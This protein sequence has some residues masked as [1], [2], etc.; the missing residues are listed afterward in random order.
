MRLK[1][2]P[3]AYEPS[4]YEDKIY[5]EWEESG[6]FNPDNLPTKPEAETYTI[7]MPPPNVTGVLH[8]GHAA[9]LALEDILI[10]YHRMQGKRTL[11]L[12]G[13]DHAAIATQTKVEK[14][15]K[16]EGLSRHSLGRE[17]FLARVREFAAQSHDTI[18]GQVKKM[19]SSC[20]WS[21]E[22]YTLDEIRTRAVRSVFKMMYD[23]GLIYRG[24]RIVNWCPRC[25]STLA[26][27]EV[28]YKTQT[29]KLYTFKYSKDFPF[30]IAT[31]RPETKLGDT[32][33]AVNPK[34]ER[35]KKYIGKTFIVDFVGVQL[36]LKIIADRSVD[37]EFGTGAL[38]VTPAHSIVDWQMAEVN[39]LEIIKVIDEDGKIRD[40]FGEFSGR[41][42]K[43]AREMIVEKLRA[44]G[45]LEKEEEIENNLSLCYRCDTPIEPLPSKQW[46]IAVNKPV[47]KFGG[48]TIKEVA[49]EVVKK[50]LGGDPKKKITIYPRRFEKN[51]FHWM[52]NLRD[53][54]ISRQI[55]FGHRIPVWYRKSSPHQIYS[56][57]GLTEDE[58]I[59]NSEIYVGVEPPEGEDWIQDPDTLDTW[60]SSGLW[61]FSTLARSS[62][63]IKIQG[64][65]L[66]INSDDFRRFHPTSVLE[67]GYDILFFW[68]ARMIIMTTYAVD[69]IPFYDVYLHGLVLDEH[70]KKMSKSKGNVIDPLDMIKKYG[71]DATRLSLIIGS[72]AGNDLRLSE[73]K[74]AG[75]RN[76]VNKLWNIS[77]YIIANQPESL[78][79]LDKQN[80]TIADKWILNKTKTLIV[81]VTNDIENYRF[82]PA[83][84]KLREFSRHDLADWYLEASKFEKSK[85]KT[86]VLNLIL[87][88]LLK[89]WHPFIP[90]V[91]EVIWGTATQ[92]QTNADWTQ[93]DA[94][95]AATQ[96]LKNAKSPDSARTNA[97]LT[98]TNTKKKLLMISQWPEA[99]IYEKILDQSK[100]EEFEIIKNII[101]VVRAARSE[102]KVEPA[103]KIKAVIYAGKHLDLVKKNEVLI[104]SLRTGIQELEIK[105]KGKKIK[106]AIFTTAGEIEIYLLGAIDKEKEKV[107]LEKEITQLE[108][109]ITASQ[110]KLQNK[111]F[112]NKAPQAVVERERDKLYRW[113][114]ELKSLKER[115]AKL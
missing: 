94:E 110:K 56:G 87:R 15:L 85:A 51:Y 75:F 17:K 69:D 28:E 39:N 27:D 65:K 49:I 74:V 2:L 40:G 70:G 13:T 100:G 48:K 43:Q 101:S 103:R 20:D 24:E 82:S 114:K 22:A 45:L 6:F 3:K 37:M 19:G 66:I 98:Q 80:L 73:E 96:S 63:Q 104:K 57:A 105:E 47:K 10:R 59:S 77:R 76:L 38:G 84:E 62:K 81:E 106:Q 78:N 46:F 92:S 99:K 88:D 5:E 79:Q 41:P 55:W 68:V 102:H 14:I 97:D 25:H 12:P 4:Q 52:Q 44:A 9:M 34:D 23:D 107:R 58:K 115:L 7:M 72:A 71:T 50:G 109:V 32:A 83:G 64:D 11:W 1:E 89:L 67:T 21:R 60:F 33:V 35:Y 18:V 53:W 108:R 36:N 26:D 95:I 42:A 111:D 93:K 61:T 91:T 54:C 112:V 86:Q 90:F 30:A 31:T 113:Q 16:A 29:T 8:M